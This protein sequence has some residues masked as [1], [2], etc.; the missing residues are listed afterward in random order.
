MPNDICSVFEGIT[1][2]QKQNFDFF[3][4]AALGVGS[5]KGLDKRS[6]Y[7]I[8]LNGA[9]CTPC[10]KLEA[11]L[12]CDSHNLSASCAPQYLLHKIVHPELGLHKLRLQ[13]P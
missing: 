4:T 6:D 9:L 5:V 10:E 8:I 11:V 1:L 13:R 12:S 3:L 7:F 2:L